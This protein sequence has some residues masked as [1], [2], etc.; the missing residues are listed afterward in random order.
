MGRW[1]HCFKGF[2]VWRTFDFKKN[3]R[4]HTAKSQ[5]GRAKSSSKFR[6][7]KWINFSLAPKFILRNCISFVNTHISQ[8]NVEVSPVLINLD[9]EQLF[10]VKTSLAGYFE[11]FLKPD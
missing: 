3:R 8:T 11:C 5:T 1:Y 4:A 7:I 9:V 10:F 6:I 2:I